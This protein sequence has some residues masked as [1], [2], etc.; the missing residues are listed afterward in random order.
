VAIA[1]EY[2]CMGQE[3]HVVWP[4]AATQTLE[5]SAG[6]AATAVAV[7]VDVP[8]GQPVQLAAVHEA[9]QIGVGV[10]AVPPAEGVSRYLAVSQ[11]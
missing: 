9:V 7:P 11:A 5:R 8:A 3:V 1:A 10:L 4:V 2:V 6:K